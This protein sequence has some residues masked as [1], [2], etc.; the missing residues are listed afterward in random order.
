MKAFY[1]TADELLASDRDQLAET[2]LRHLKSYEGGG[3]VHQPV[4]GF[5]RSYYIQTMDG[6]I[7]M[8]G[9]LPTTPEYGDKQPQVSR[10]VQ[11]AWQRLVTTGYLMH[12]PGQ[13]NSDWHVITTEGEELLSI[14]NRFERWEQIGVDL[15]KQD[16]AAGGRQ[17]VGGPPTVRQ[18][19]IEWVR[20]KEGQAMLP[21]G[22]HPGTNNAASFI[23]ESRIEEIRN[24]A[25]PDFDFQK[26]IRLCEELNSSYHEGNLYATAMLTRALLDHV[27]PIFGKKTF[28]E[29]A[30][31]YGGQSF[32]A[33]MQHLD[34][35]SRKVSDDH[36]HGQIRK[37]DTLP[38][39]QQVWCGQQLDVLLA[40]I[41]R[42][43]T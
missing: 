22:K 28:T 11:E 39:P 43:I 42:T 34:N 7:R 32:K 29:V 13:P 38:T 31:N 30:N 14:L 36:L 21:A 5:N 1:P 10:R 40:E 16:L 18:Q 24:L 12:N 25:S 6:T 35:A 37:K 23:A 9:P 4:G 27:P 19:A 15:V 41:V 33:T 17:F 2:V 20:M 26:L 3:T 8:L